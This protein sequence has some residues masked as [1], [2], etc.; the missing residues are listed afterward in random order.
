MLKTQKP[1]K[2]LLSALYTGDVFHL[3][4]TAQT[5]ALVAT[6]RAAL[7]DAFGA[8]L[9]AVHERLDFS[10]MKQPLADIRARLER[11][12]DFAKTCNNILSGM[13]LPDMRRDALRLRCVM[14]GGHES[15]AAERDRKSVV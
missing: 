12:E 4:A 1:E 2:D 13:G 9:Q 8:D 10:A 11:E 5:A 3:T 14:H 6:V 15:P 7:E